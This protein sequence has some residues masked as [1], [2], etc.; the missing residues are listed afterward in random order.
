MKV[1]EGIAEIH[2]KEASDL[3]QEIL[4]DLE[5]REEELRAT[6]AKRPKKKKKSVVTKKKPEK[7]ACDIECKIDALDC[8][9]EQI[10]CMIDD[11]DI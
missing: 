8:S 11:L 5:K 1:V 4:E 7:E 3:A 10:W 6:E 9:E 2:G